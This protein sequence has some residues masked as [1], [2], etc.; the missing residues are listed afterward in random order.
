MTLFSHCN[1][2]SKNTAVC[3]AGLAIPGH[4][5]PPF[6]IAQKFFRVKLKLGASG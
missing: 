5:I 4:Q 1:E 6:V 2:T 3:K